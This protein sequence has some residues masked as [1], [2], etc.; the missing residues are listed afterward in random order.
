MVQSHLH[1]SHTSTSAEKASANTTNLKYLNLGPSVQFTST[2][3]TASS[4]TSVPV[5]ASS[6]TSVTSTLNTTVASTIVTTIG[7][8][9]FNNTITTTTA[10]SLDA[11]N[12][13]T[14]GTSLGSRQYRSSSL[15]H[16]PTK[17]DYSRS[18]MLN[19]LTT[20]PPAAAVA[21]AAVTP[22][23]AAVA[24]T[25]ASTLSSKDQSSEESRVIN[26]SRQ[27]YSKVLWP[28]DNTHGDE[29]ALS[30]INS[31]EAKNGSELSAIN[32]K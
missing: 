28:S 7:G 31:T 3:L 13:E 27:N 14:S 25:T 10:N 2:A 29:L 15:T 11:F 20:P 24:A 22:T 1:S 17:L 30:S 9:I 6:S 32:S 12:K 8:T 21:A 16:V 18:T 19:H 4:T 5:P 26:K 23:P